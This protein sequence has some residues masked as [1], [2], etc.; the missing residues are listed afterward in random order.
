MMMT[1]QKICELWLRVFGGG[2]Y[3]AFF[4]GFLLVECFAGGW[5]GECGG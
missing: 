5:W 4:T 3:E 1:N 2:C